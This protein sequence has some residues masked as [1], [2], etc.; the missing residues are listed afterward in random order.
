MLFYAGMCHKATRVATA[1]AFLADKKLRFQAKMTENQAE[2]L[3]D[4]TPSALPVFLH[5]LH[6]DVFDDVREGRP[7]RIA[8]RVP[9]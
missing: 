1:R 3:P 6:H 4:Q 9:E 8:H 7:S 5:I 2:V